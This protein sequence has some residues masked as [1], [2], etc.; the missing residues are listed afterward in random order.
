MHL[1]I[2]SPFPPT[3][4]GIGQYG[5]HI[6]RAI[7]K[8][9]SFSRVTV[10]AGAKNASGNRPV[11]ENTEIEYCWRP[12]EMGSLRAIPSRLKRLNP[13]LVWMNLGASVFGRSPLANLSGMFLPL[14]A[15][16]M[17]YPTIVTLHE[18]VELADL[19]ALNAPGGILAPL[20]ARLLTNV[21][22]RADLVC[23]TMKYYA[24]WLATNKPDVQCLYIP[25]GIF[26]DPEFLQESTEQELLFFST[27]APFKGLELL[28]DVFPSLQ[29]EFPNLGLTV[30]G[31]DHVRYPEYANQIKTRAGGMKNVRWHGQVAEEMIVDMFRRAQIVVLPYTASTGSS[32]VM[33]R[34]ATWGRAVIASNLKEHVHFTRENDL[35]IEFFENGNAQSLK[36]SLYALLKSRELRRQQTEHNFRSIQR[37][38]PG[39]TCRHYIH[40]FNRALESRRSQKRIALPR[41]ELE[42]L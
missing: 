38:T 15:R 12:D 36:E 25:H 7:E 8:S 13:D 29:M 40:A 37:L 4:T 41:R 42:L 6:T 11:L 35:K 24:D 9:G 26:H 18:L 17:G 22:T 5:F 39:E 32:S 10:L 28:L 20:G 16:K 3:I 2:V 33:C 31:T 1:A 21:A 30:A 19:R 27:L 23:L 14:L 34:A